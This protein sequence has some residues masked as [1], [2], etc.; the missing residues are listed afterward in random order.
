M[1]V[2]ELL[3]RDLFSQHLI[4]RTSREMNHIIGRPV[5][6]S[7]GRDD[8]HAGEKA[9]KAIGDRQSSD[10]TTRL[11]LPCSTAA[12]VWC[13]STRARVSRSRTHA[14]TCAHAQAPYISPRS[15][16]WSIYRPPCLFGQLFCLS[17]CLLQARRVGSLLL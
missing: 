15:L 11:L 6:R 2:E 1:P 7:A 5:S 16:T 13:V 14:R 12:D 8:S 17:E 10:T 9:D 4:Y 3:Q